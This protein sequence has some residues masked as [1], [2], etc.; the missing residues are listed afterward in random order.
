M[1]VLTLIPSLRVNSLHPLF[2]DINY[3]IILSL[4]YIF[5]YII[6][7]YVDKSLL[8]GNALGLKAIDPK[9]K[10]GAH[11]KPVVF[12]HP[13]SVNGVLLELEQK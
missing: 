7:I 8:F 5:V 13:K 1:G 10:I 2:L 4:G 6:Y 9:P 12:L 11:G 3:I